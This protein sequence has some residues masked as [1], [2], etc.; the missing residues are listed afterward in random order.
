MY[1]LEEVVYGLVLGEL[2]VVPEELG[3]VLIGVDR[4]E[5]LRID[6]QLGGVGLGVDVDVGFLDAPD[7]GLDLG[8]VL[9]GHLVVDHHIVEIA[10]LIS[11]L[12][13][14]APV[15]LQV[16]LEHLACVVHC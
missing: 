13:P 4:P 16:E 6:E 12:D 15:Q 8:L 2:G 14:C 3:E 7:Q 1:D 5:L 9:G 11:T 10:H